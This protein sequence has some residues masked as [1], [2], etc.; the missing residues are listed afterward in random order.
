MGRAQLVMTDDIR[1]RHL[2]PPGATQEM[3]RL[4]RGIAQEAGIGDHCEVLFSRHRIPF[5]EADAGVVDSEGW[6]DDAAQ[7]AP[8]LNCQTLDDGSGVSTM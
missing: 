1:I 3:L 2:F 7:T 5:L 4:D 6:G 8:V